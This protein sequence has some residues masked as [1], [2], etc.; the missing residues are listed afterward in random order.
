MY[1]GEALG[2][3]VANRSAQIHIGLTVGATLAGSF[4]VTGILLGSVLVLGGSIVA[5]SHPRTR[6]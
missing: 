3:D 4:G 2:W 5:V 6:R 1:A